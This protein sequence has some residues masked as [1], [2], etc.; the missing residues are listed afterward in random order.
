MPLGI[1]RE[2][3][4]RKLLSILAVGLFAAGASGQARAAAVAFNGSLAIQFATLDPLAVTGS[5]IAT[6]DGLNGDHI[7][8]L[9]LPA[10][11]FSLQGL[12]LPITDPAAV[13]IKGVQATLHNAAGHF[14]GTPLG[15]TM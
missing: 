5:G 3:L 10:S 7:T 15:G 8:S 12:V 13:P 6:V 1:L 9:D 4:M 14:D 11:P 2:T